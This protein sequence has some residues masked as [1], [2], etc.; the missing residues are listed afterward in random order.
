M[1][2][3][4][5]F[6]L[7]VFYQNGRRRRKTTT[8]TAQRL[9]L[10]KLSHHFLFSGGLDCIGE[11]ESTQRARQIL[12]R[13]PFLSIRFEPEM[14][15]SALLLRHSQTS[16]ENIHQADMSRAPSTCRGWPGQEGQQVSSYVP[17]ATYQQGL[18]N[19]DLRNPETAEESVMVI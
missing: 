16:R 12:T 10:K 14:D 11:V 18:T 3:T 8:T 19:A 2:K 4:I 1:G 6:M 17:T 13:Y 15:K 5:N 7:C 9:I